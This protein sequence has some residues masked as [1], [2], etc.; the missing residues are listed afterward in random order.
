MTSDDFMQKGL[1]FGS[2]SKD[3][4]PDQMKKKAIL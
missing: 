3:L 4:F 1:G 2:L